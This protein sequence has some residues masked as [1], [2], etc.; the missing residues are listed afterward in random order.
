[1]A[2]TS[3]PEE[4]RPSTPS[5]SDVAATPLSPAPTPHRVSQ[6]GFLRRL[7]TGTGVILQILALVVIL[8]LVNGFAYKH[9]H[10]FDFSRDRKSALS[11]R[12]KQ[13]LAS[14]KQ[15]VKMIVFFS[16]QSQLQGDVSNLA[17]EYRKVQPKYISLEQVDPYRNVGRATEVATKYKLAHSGDQSENVVVL[18]CEGRTKIIGEDKLAEFDN[19][20]M[21]MGQASAPQITAFLGEQAI[22]SGLLEVSEGKKSNIYYL[23][24][25]GESGF[26]KGQPLDIVGTLLEGEHLSTSEL[27]LLNVTAVPADASVVML[28]GARTDLTEREGQLLTDYWAKGGRVLVLLNPDASTPNIAAFL[29]KVGIQPDDDRVLATVPMGAYTGI[30]RDTLTSLTGSTPIATQLTG[31]TP[32]FPGGAQSLTLTPD[33]LKAQGVKLAP[34]LVANPKFW[35]ETNYKDLENTGAY[36]D[37]TDK[38]A[39]LYIAATVEKGGVGDQ[40]MQVGAARMIVVGQARFTERGMMDERS[41]D[42]FLSSLNWLLERESLIAIAPK[43]VQTF[44]LNLPDSQTQLFFEL[45]VLVIPAFCAFL[46]LL[47]WWRRRA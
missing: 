29:G 18:E 24:G 38:H 4:P 20:A 16:P 37:P 11:P 23:Q 21:M 47:V 27:N 6:A 46:G 34:L 12:T 28:I 30:V 10:R 39:P 32:V 7:S 31:V 5:E 25:H 8:A 17:E 45:T 3:A 1:M 40:R 41:G 19:S 14:L 26:A 9:Y 33:P 13:F 35:G 44:T 15:P 22:T 36:D 43:H 2:A 42:F